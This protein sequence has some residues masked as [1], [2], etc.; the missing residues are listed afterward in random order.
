MSG[1]N[2][3]FVSYMLIY[4]DGA[5][6][7]Y[8]VLPFRGASEVIADLEAVANDHIRDNKTPTVQVLCLTVLP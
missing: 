6:S 5:E 1:M 4:P 7:G 8:S 2:N 3:Y